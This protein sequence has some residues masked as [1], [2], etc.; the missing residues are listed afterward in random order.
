[1]VVLTRPRWWV[2]AASRLPYLPLCWLLGTSVQKK[3]LES[4]LLVSFCLQ[5]SS[6][7]GRIGEHICILS[8]GWSFHTSQRRSLCSLFSSLSSN[9]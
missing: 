8:V 6:D 2:L 1:M 9:E 5:E 7:K 3:Y 4:N